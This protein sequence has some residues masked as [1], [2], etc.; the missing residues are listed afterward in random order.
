MA[1]TSVSRESEVRQRGEWVNPV[2]G[3][4]RQAWLVIVVAWGG[5]LLVNMDAAMFTFTY[6][7]IQEELGLSLSA[8]SYIYTTIFVV[9]AVVTFAMG[10]IMDRFGRRLLFNA[11]MAFTALGS[12]LTAISGGLASM[13]L[14]RSITQVGAS[15]ELAAGQVM[16]AEAAPA[17]SRGWW[18]GFA[19]TGWPVGWF[20]ASGLAAVVVPTLGWRALFVIGLIPAL[21]IVFVRL[22]VK[23]SDRFEDV[24]RLR[25]SAQ[26]EASAEHKSVEDAAEHVRTKY[27]VKKHEAVHSTYRQLLA[28]DLRRTTIL[29][30]LWQAIY[31]YGAAGI[32]YWLPSI[33]LANNLSLTNVYS[34]S[35]IANV[36]GALGYVVAATLGNR[37]GRREVSVLW[38]FLGGIVGIFFWLYGDTWA[39]ITIFYSLFYFFT[40]GHMGAAPGFALE[41]F[42]TRVRGTGMSVFSAAVWVGFI[43]AAL[44]GPPLFA[45]IGESGA[46]L[47]WAG[48]AS[49]AAAAFA[50][51]MR[52]VVPGQELESVA[53]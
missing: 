51:G 49:F 10:P 45:A 48:V 33:V 36:C 35:A 38:L 4:N 29:I 24:R 17:K 32:I 3:L 21:F 9:G 11:T 12:V 31:N 1:N 50:L 44:S 30:F 2:E 34:A 15:G 53:V 20:V 42:P 8:V 46:V 5:W 14:Y 27:P 39:T 19:Q 6:P 26:R 41:S 23:E 47:V 28:P 43:A 25:E 22:F 18:N 16:L 13:I 52:R 37:Y 7:L 40:I